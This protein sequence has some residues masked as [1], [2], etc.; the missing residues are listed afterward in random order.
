[1]KQKTSSVKKITNHDESPS[2]RNKRG[3]STDPA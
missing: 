2:T 1:M 3:V